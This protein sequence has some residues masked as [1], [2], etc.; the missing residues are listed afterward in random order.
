MKKNES[1]ERITELFSDL[2]VDYGIHYSFD[3]SLSDL[4]FV[5]FPMPYIKI[6][7]NKIKK[8]DSGEVISLVLEFNDLGMF[9]TSKSKIEIE[10]LIK[11]F[12]KNT[13]L[14]KTISVKFDKSKYQ[15]I[16]IAPDINGEIGFSAFSI[17]I[18]DTLVE[19][20]SGY[21]IRNIKIDIKTK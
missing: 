19:K 5:F 16:E 6:L 17:K 21:Y 14:Q 7:E 13:I 4:I 10:A 9:Y 2:L 12:D 8:R 18:N 11:D 15:M 20:T 3:T 1:Y